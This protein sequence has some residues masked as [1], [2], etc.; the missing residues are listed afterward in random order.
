MNEKPSAIDLLKL[1]ILSFGKVLVM[2]FRNNWEPFYTT[3]VKMGIVSLVLWGLATL[4][5][6]GIPI[7]SAISYLGWL[8]IIIVYR[9]VTIKYDDFDEPEL[10]EIETD[11][12]EEIDDTQ[13]IV[14]RQPDEPIRN[15]VGKREEEYDNNGSTRE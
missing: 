15:V 2:I 1:L 14:G 11:D 9:L 3:S 6:H 5:P 12:D 8:T 4:I 7:L 13:T 10:A